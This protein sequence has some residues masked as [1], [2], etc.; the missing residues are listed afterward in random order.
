[1]LKKPKQTKYSKYQKGNI[2]Y[3][4]KFKKFSFEKS[5]DSPLI[6]NK[7]VLSL[8]AL[9]PARF[10]AA[11][12]AAAELAIKRKIKKE[13]SLNTRV[14]PHFPVTKKPLEVRMGKGKGS[15]S[16]W[17]TRIQPGSF[18]FELTCSNIELAKLALKVASSKLPFKTT[19][20]QFK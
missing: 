11:Q 16:Y 2:S 19:I 3:N 6:N 9:E 12:I 1:M 5:G 17:M 13:G 20:I 4:F 14:F 8:V 10:T 18:L 7:I 15:I